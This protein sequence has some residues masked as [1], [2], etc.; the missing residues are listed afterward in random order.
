MKATKAERN[1]IK[2]KQVQFMQNKTGIVYEGL[3]SGVTEWGMY[4]EIIENKCEGM[5][6]L[7][8]IDDDFYEFDEKNFCLI[9]SKRRKRY[10]LGDT[11]FVKIKSTDLTRKQIDFFLVKK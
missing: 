9:G 11:V 6:R 5:V 2:F 1:S 4:V 10:T 7:R 8:D 3:I